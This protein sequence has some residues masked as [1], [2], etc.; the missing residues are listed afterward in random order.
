MG[1]RSPARPAAWPV[2]AKMPAPIMTPVPSDTAPM[3]L[4]LSG[5]S[6]GAR[7]SVPPGSWPMDVP[8]VMVANPLDPGGAG[9]VVEHADPDGGDGGEPGEAGQQRAGLVEGGCLLYT[10]PSPRDG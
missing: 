8:S 9:E 4:K 3:R 5:T 7:R 10:S 6:S 2:M 1:N